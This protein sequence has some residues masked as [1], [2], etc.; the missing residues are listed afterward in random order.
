MFLP[1][2][3]LKSGRRGDCKDCYRARRGP[4]GKE[5]RQARAL[6]RVLLSLAET[7][8]LP[9]LADILTRAAKEARQLGATG[10]QFDEQVE[11]VRTAIFTHGCRSAEEIEEETRLSRYVVDRGLADLLASGAV[12]TRDRFLLT[13]EAVEPGRPVT[14][15]HPADYPRGE[16]FTHLIY[17]S[18]EDNLL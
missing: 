5:A 16:D 1:D 8:P 3:R 6:E 2:S 17:S 11:A 15:Y 10:A 7:Y 18:A 14:E 4:R 12:E 9:S 13:D